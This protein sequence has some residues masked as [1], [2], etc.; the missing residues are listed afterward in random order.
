MKLSTIVTSLVLAFATTTAAQ[1][2]QYQ[3][4][5][6]HKTA[7]AGWEAVGRLNI[8][9]N[10]MCTGALIAPDIVLTAAHCLHNPQTGASVNPKNIR[11]DAGLKNGRASA[12]RMVSRAVKHPQYKFGHDAQLGYDLALLY[13]ASPIN[14]ANIVPF[15]TD[16]RPGRGDEVGVVSYSLNQQNTA[17]IEQPCHVLARQHDTLVMTCDVEFGAS[18]APVFAVTG[19]QRPQLVSVISAKAKV[20]RRKVSIG[21]ALEGTLAMMLKQG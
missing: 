4:A 13:L 12:Q 18:G 14:D 21:T 17:R 10:N 6:K 5:A 20:N 16:A 2:E 7:P 11:F 9:G 1:A 19:G 3:R 15:S 8:A